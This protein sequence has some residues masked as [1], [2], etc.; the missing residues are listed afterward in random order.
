MKK[1]DRGYFFY[2][3]LADLVPAFV[4]SFIFCDELMLTDAEGEAL[5]VNTAAIPL[6]LGLLAIAYLVLLV[7]RF[8][9]L[10]TAGYRLGEHEILCCR[11]VFFRKKSL[12]EYKR[13]NAVNKKQN[14]LHRL[15]GIAILTL[16]S[17]STTAA[18]TAEITVIEKDRVIDDL[19]A[20][21]KAHRDAARG[22]APRDAAPEGETLHFD[23]EESLY[24]LTP[25]KK[26]MY[27]LVNL[28]TAA[29]WSAL[30]CIAII[31]VVGFLVA[32]LPIV[33][34]A[35]AIAMT[36]IISLIVLFGISLIS[37][38]CSL[39]SGFLGFY[40]FHVK[41]TAE[42]LVVSYGLLVKSVNSFRPD[43]IRG[44][45]IR[46]SLID[47]LFGTASIRLEV[48]GYG[49]AAGGEEQQNAAEG[50]LVPLCA[51]RE[52]PELLARLLPEYLPEE[53]AIKPKK[54]APFFLWPLLI[55][56]LAFLLPVGLL[57]ASLAICS[58]SGGVIALV[59]G[60]SALV[61]LSCLSV[62]SL[63][64]FLAYKNSG[65]AIGDGKVTAYGGDYTRKISVLRKK[66]L[67][68]V[69]EV[70]TPLQKKAGIGSCSLHFRSNAMSNEVKILFLEE[71]AFCRL[72]EEV[73]D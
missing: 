42:E 30:V 15:F 27:A 7:Y 10:R 54:A 34:D 1:F 13:I 48:I 62:L 47:R 51:L 29:F 17:G 60:I 2:H 33:A 68:A 22:E 39:I 31:G 55:L 59:G 65:L 69:E 6:F 53:A 40:G 38:L 57:L 52:V 19:M 45:S 3:L 63:G 71:A 4:F 50:F 67:M 8:L 56:S 26:L 11:G 14:L 18:A 35:G 5:G 25:V 37:F 61:F 44:V 70:A 9:Y 58:V 12:L 43:K 72:R 46:Q 64:R 73:K 24:T 28:V 20:E 41:K 36:A 23:A 21:I 16:D 32:C 49:A 66:E